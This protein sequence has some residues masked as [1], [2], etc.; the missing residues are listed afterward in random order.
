MRLRRVM[1]SRICGG[2]TPFRRVRQGRT[3]L[4]VTT[5]WERIPMISL[6]GNREVCVGILCD[7]T[8]GF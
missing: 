2:E 1:A 3:N 4:G 5:T 8:L 7:P 6:P